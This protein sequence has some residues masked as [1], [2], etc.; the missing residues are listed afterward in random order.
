[1]NKR[2]LSRGALRAGRAVPRERIIGYVEPPEEVFRKL[3]LEGFRSV[4]G[5]EIDDVFPANQTARDE[6]HR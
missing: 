1:M 4:R 2:I 6:V 3:L 5:M